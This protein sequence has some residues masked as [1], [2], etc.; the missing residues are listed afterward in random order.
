MHNHLMRLMDHYEKPKL[1][2][3]SHVTHMDDTLHLRVSFMLFGITRLLLTHFAVCNCASWI[4]HVVFCPVNY[5]YTR[6]KLIGSA[7]ISCVVLSGLVVP[8]WP[9]PPTPTLEIWTR[10]N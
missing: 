7:W 9:T 1:S 4:F 3:I 10:T 5:P 8:A 6:K 2:H